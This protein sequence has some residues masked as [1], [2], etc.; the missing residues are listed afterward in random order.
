[1]K[2]MKRFLGF[3]YGGFGVICLD[4]EGECTVDNK[5]SSLVVVLHN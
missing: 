2:V 1:M 3:G 4:D 5:K